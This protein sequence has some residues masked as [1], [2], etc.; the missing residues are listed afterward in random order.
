MTTIMPSCVSCIH[1][2]E[3]RADGDFCNAFPDGHG[4]PREILTNRHDHK[5]PYPGDHGIQFE[6]IDASL[7]D[8][9]DP[10]DRR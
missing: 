6:P 1:F 10:D 8:D 2:H 4:I 9:A 5:T 3:Q 7:E